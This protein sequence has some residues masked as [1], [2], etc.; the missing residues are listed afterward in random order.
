MKT[1]RKTGLYALSGAAALPCPPAGSAAGKD[2]AGARNG[3]ADFSCLHLPSESGR[4]AQ[5]HHI[6]KHRRLQ[7]GGVGIDEEKAGVFERSCAHSF[8]KGKMLSSIFQISPLGP[9]P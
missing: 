6:G 3:K 1:G 8:T 4:N 5:M 9:R 2:E 7:A